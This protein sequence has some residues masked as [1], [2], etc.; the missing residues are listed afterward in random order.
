MTEQK[1]E[2]PL[3][4][5]KMFGDG[6]SRRGKFLSSELSLTMRRSPGGYSKPCNFCRAWRALCCDL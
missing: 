3:L 2:L 5:S 6:P 4:V 1:V